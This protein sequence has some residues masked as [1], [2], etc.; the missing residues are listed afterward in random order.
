MSFVTDCKQC[1]CEPV[2]KYKNVFREQVKV[3][4][5]GTI[6]SEKEGGIWRVKDCPH[7]RVTVECPYW[8]V[9]SN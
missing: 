2:C 7:I 8:T 1:L 6:P 4:A 9:K 3:I 5:E